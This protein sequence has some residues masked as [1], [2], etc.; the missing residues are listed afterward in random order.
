[1]LVFNVATIDVQR[2]EKNTLQVSR[3][4]SSCAVHVINVL[5]MQAYALVLDDTFDD[6]YNHHIVLM[7][8]SWVRMKP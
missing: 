1:M 4:S 7:M 2:V 5:F 3:R 6:T 8:K